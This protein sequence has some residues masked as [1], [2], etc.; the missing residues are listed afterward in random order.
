MSHLIFIPIAAA[1]F[2]AYLAIVILIGRFLKAATSHPVALD[3][4]TRTIV[5]TVEDEMATSGPVQLS[6][7]TPARSLLYGPRTVQHPLR[8]V[9][10]AT[11]ESVREMLVDAPVRGAG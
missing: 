6:K 5:G 11:P 4:P 9:S 8:H 3:T 2:I 1:A 7:A 10:K